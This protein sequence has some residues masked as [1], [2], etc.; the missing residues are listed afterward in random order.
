MATYTG[1]PQWQ[2]APV[3]AAQTAAAAAAAGTAQNNPSTTGEVRSVTPAMNNTRGS[4]AMYPSRVPSP[5]NVSSHY[6][7]RN[8]SPGHQQHSY[9][10]NNNAT[11][12]G[13]VPD[14]N[15]HS[16][17]ANANATAN[18]TAT[19]TANAGPS[20]TGLIRL[21]LRKP[22]GIVF[23][24]MY[25]PNQPSVQ[26]GV[27]ICDLPR[28][29]AAAL[30][31]KLEIGDELL[32]INDKT[33][34]RLTFD[35]I[36]D[37]IIEADP[38]QVNLL[39]RRPRKEVL[40]ARNALKAAP[41]T[42]SSSQSEKANV[43][44]VDDDH[45]HNNGKAKT[46]NQKNNNQS[47]HKNRNP[48]K[49]QQQKERDDDTL[50][51][52]EEKTSNNKKKNRKDPYENESFLDLLIDTICANPD[53]VCKSDNRRND[54]DSE[55]ED[56]DDRTLTSYDDSTYVTY[57]SSDNK[58]PSKNNN[59]KNQDSETEDDAT[60]AEEEEE[61][62]RRRRFK[63]MKKL[64]YEDDATLETTETTDRPLPAV[65]IKAP[66]LLPIVHEVILPPQQQLP[67]PPPAAA[68]VRKKPTPVMPIKL[69]QEE[70]K[71]KAPILELEYD[72]QVDADV[73]VMESLG[74]PSL[75]IEQR[76]QMAT[77]TTTLANKD[78]TVPSEIINEFGQDY[79]V[80]YGF[81]K[82]QSIASNPIKFYAF[83]V[84][85]LLEEH[86]PEKVRLLDKLLAKY[87]GREDHLVQKLSVRYKRDNDN[88]VDDEPPATQPPEE[89]DASFSDA[90]NK[91]KDSE[92]TERAVQKAQER[93]AATF[94]TWPQEEA[95]EEESEFSGGDS[96]DG[97]S[98][99]VIA[100]VS[101]LLNYV[102][103]K[104]SVPGQI[105]RVSTIMRAYEGREAVLLEL[106][107][108]K[109][110]IKANSEKENAGILPSFLRNSVDGAGVEQQQESSHTVP[111]VH[112][113]ISSMSGVSSP[114]II[115][116]TDN[117]VHHNNNNKA[118][119]MMVR[120]YCLYIDHMSILLLTFF[121]NSQEESHK[122]EKMSSNKIRTPSVAAT[123]KKKGLF[124]GLFTKKNRNRRIKE[125]QGSI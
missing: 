3:V 43:K 72:D 125:D 75:L 96:I 7:N 71:Y 57:E 15:Q 101:E 58:K 40:L 110:L 121:P 23:E 85:I 20:S 18:A 122:S 56:E 65:V 102:Y 30:T 99:A 29:G 28:T 103:G 80:T 97:T 13:G 27:R 62:E 59:K 11:A 67:P 79:P 98:P 26:K 123:K 47:K 82:E 39:F 88:E 64:K 94:G 119:M 6:N 74:G 50:E 52:Y 117:V 108:T 44:W 83:V 10:N 2:P 84:K 25:D 78:N 9:Y 38:E 112:D 55:D 12:T 86:E 91:H 51:T 54:Y 87:K 16:A 14:S 115:I 118:V 41:P 106:L 104:T 111:S 124:G 5:T 33:M 77:T 32:S 114:A 69:P 100:Q 34:S 37:F 70:V 36:M 22:M 4:S 46:K 19:A 116:P 1:V 90:V 21:T 63:T 8:M 61:E 17:A 107:E 48:K 120:L 66:P 105:D 60:F 73:S 68:T 109:A 95:S 93:A 92:T 113:D 81:T 53:S 45:H 42:K 24:P 89:E 31:R 35:E 49:Q 76:R